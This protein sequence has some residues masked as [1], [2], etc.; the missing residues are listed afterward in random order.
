MATLPKPPAP[1]KSSN[2]GVKIGDD[3]LNNV[4]S[5][6]EKAPKVIPSAPVPPPPV[7]KSGGSVPP[8]PIPVA[9]PVPTPTKEDTANESEYLT[10]DDD[11]EEYLTLDDDEDEI[12]EEPKKKQKK[13]K[14]EKVKKNKD[15]D[16]EKLK[17]QSKSQK[18][19]NFFVE[20]MSL[21]TIVELIIIFAFGFAIPF[22]YYYFLTGYMLTSIIVG[23]ASS[24][25]FFY[26]FSY[27]TRILTR[28][29][30]QL[31]TLLK[32]V[33]NMKFYLASGEIINNAYEKTIVA[34]TQPDVKKDLQLTHKI[35]NEQAVLATT[36]FEKYNLPSIDQFHNN[37][38]IFYKNGGDVSTLFDVVQKNM[39]KELEKRDRLYQ[40]R[41]S[42]VSE[43]HILLGLVIAI[44]VI[45]KVMV[46][47]QWVLFN[48]NIIGSTL[49]MY[50]TIAGIYYV[51]AAAQKHKRDISVTIED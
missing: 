15:D 21:Y 23:L 41:K 1:P 17:K 10:L 6:Y 4:Q 11:T 36:Q 31:N 29:Q 46:S 49:V 40:Q 43:I 48:N 39:L 5:K 28:Y 27:K 19:N 24:W 3:V 26:V 16:L 51:M 34:I 37:L 30:D 13:K 35:L 32:Y 22:A 18:M 9:I 50:L 12:I 45:V 14:K 44:P 25:F 8:P 33:T 2:G 20:V 47:S 38:T 42:K 7:T